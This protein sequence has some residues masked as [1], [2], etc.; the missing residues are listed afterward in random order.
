MFGRILCS[1]TA[2]GVWRA[3]DRAIRVS[4]GIR[5]MARYSTP[6]TNSTP[7]TDSAPAKS[8]SATHSAPANSDPPPPR[9]SRPPGTYAIWAMEAIGATSAFLYYLHLYTDLL[10]PPVT[11]R[12]NPL[13]YSPHTLINSTP[14]T[15]DTTEFRFRT[16]RPRFDGDLEHKVDEVIQQGVW[17]IDIK[18][19][20]VQTYRTYTPIDYKVGE[21][22]DERGLRPGHCDFVV[23]RY[24]NGSL[25]RF[26]HNT[27]VGDSVEMRGPHVS[28]P[29]EANTYRQV[30]MV[31][32]GTGIAPMVQ[33][34]KR[35]I[36][37]PTDNTKFSLL[38]GSQTEADI[39]CR[40]QLD[41]IA[42]QVPERLQIEYLVDQ[43]PATVAR[44]GRPD[45]HNVG[46]LV[47]G[48]DQT[49][50]VVLVCGPDAMMQVV[51]GIRPIGPTQGPLRGALRDLGFAPQS[52]FKF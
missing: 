5:Q 25:S 16:N 28:W 13:K 8:D 49:K 39:L 42:E 26:V 52:V 48:F 40:E 23:K 45:T 44:V 3:N 12:L 19:H 1:A 41:Q 22:D 2:R 35:A 20:L 38:Y 4:A 29:Y 36:A 30:F 34:I 33:L 21:V 46:R 47:E 51:S 15:K 9:N 24:A 17:S 10:K 31:A 27:R 50:D 6:S 43:G 18:D 14:L 7:L 37:D 32:G 11:D